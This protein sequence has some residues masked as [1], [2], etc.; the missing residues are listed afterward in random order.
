[1]R[2]AL[3]KGLSQ[4]IAEQF[5]TAPTEV[6][7]DAIQPNARQP[8][9]HF[10]PEGL[11]EL[12]ASIREFGVIQPLIVRPLNEDAYELIA[13]ERRLRAAKIAGLRTVPI[14]IRPAGHQSSLEM[15]LIENVQRED[16]NAIEC[17]RAYRRLIDEF[18]LTQEQVADKVGKSRTAVANTVRLLRLPERVQEGLEE[19]RITE[20]HAKALL[21]F[22]SEAQQLAVYDEILERGLT[23]REVEKA[24]KPKAD[25]PAKKDPAPPADPNDDS[26][27]DALSIYLGSPVRIAR[28]EAG[29]RLVVDFYS[30][31]DLERILEILGFRF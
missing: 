31:E 17:A 16:I 22:E 9:T 21:A 1:M 20:G 30:D 14:I 28:H 24:S 4:L 23:V 13:G 5:E 3:G 15:A 2:R 18:G 19:G 7:V 6:A 12:A 10:D 25:P 26:L 27:A 29:G 11:N 8:R